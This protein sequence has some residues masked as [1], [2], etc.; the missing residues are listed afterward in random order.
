MQVVPVKCGG[1]DNQLVWDDNK[2]CLYCV[3]QKLKRQRNDLLKA[4]EVLQSAWF[5]AQEFPEDD[6]RKFR[7]ASALVTILSREIGDEGKC[8]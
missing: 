2:N 5:R 7:E 8:E 3:S 1:C 6:A 4:A